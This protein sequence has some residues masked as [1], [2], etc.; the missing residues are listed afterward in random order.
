[1]YLNGKHF[2]KLIFNTIEAKVIILACNVKP[3]ETITIKK[4]TFSQGRSYWNP[5]N[6]FKQFSQKPL[7]QFTFN[8]IQRLFMIGLPKFYKLLGS[9]DQDGRHAHIK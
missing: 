5:I 9:H 3:N 4:V 8:V 7:S 2:E 1:M 6:I